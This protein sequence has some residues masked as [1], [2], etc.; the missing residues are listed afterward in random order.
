MVGLGSVDNTADASKPISTA[1]QTALDLKAPLA[2]PALTG[3][4]TSTT[5][6]PGTNNTQIATTAYTD[7]A[8]AALVDS[9]PTTLNTLDELAL[10]L[11]DDANF[12]TTTATAIGLKAPKLDPEF[13]GTPLAP[14]A[15]VG[16]NTTQ[17]ATTAFV[18]AANPTGAVIA[19][20]GSS[21]PAGWLLCSGQEVA[22]SSYGALYAVVGTTYGSLTNGSLGVGTTHF[23]L[24]DLRG[25]TVMGTGTG[26]YAGATAR[27]LSATTGAETVTLT[28][29]QSGVP[30]HQHANTLGSNTVASSSHS[31]SA[32]TL[33]AGMSWFKAG[34]N[35]YL[36]FN[37]AGI[38]GGMAENNRVQ[39]PAGGFVA[40]NNEGSTSGIGVF[41][42]TDAN[43]SNT[44]VSISNVN[45]TAANAAESHSVMQPTMVLNYIIKA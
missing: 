45:N 22:I 15:A 3:T 39:F 12:A 34:D 35:I 24:P 25:R 44:T 7:A 11:G 21:A 41:N 43:A 40:G 42:S 33:A 26:T 28:S 19:F 5:A 4:P 30:A 36:D 8:V 13:T 16:T 9:A 6:T 32:G 38:P 37:Y 29:A 20:A 14:T 18:Q 31:H 23:R 2:S 1:Q 17:I 10:A 27:A